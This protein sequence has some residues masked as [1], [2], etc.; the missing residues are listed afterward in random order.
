MQEPR[1]RISEL[2]LKIR[3]MQGPSQH[4]TNWVGQQSNSRRSPRGSRKGPPA[5]E[6]GLVR[7]AATGLRDSQ[8]DESVIELFKERCDMFGLDTQTFTPKDEREKELAECG[9]DSS[10]DSSKIVISSIKL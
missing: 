10:A 4:P 2:L 1:L 8:E 5:G 7:L 6:A 3:L 9:T